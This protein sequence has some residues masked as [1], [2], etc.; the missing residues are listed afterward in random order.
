MSGDPLAII[1]LSSPK[2]QNVDNGHAFNLITA[3][4]LPAIRASGRRD[5]IRPAGLTDGIDA[6]PIVDLDLPR[7]DFRCATLEFLIGLLTVACPPRDDWSV[8]WTSPPSKA[9]LEAAF[10]PFVAAFTLDGEGAR[11][12]QDFEDLAIEPTPVEALLI[13][14]PGAAT[15]KR[16]AALLVKPGRVEVLSRSAAAIALLTL[17]TMA[18]AGGAGHRTSLR[19]GGPLTTLVVPTT[20]ATLWH[21]LWA[22]VPVGDAHPV[23]AELPRIFPWLAPTRLSNEDGRTTTP[24]DVDWRQA[25]FGVPRRIRLD[26]EPNVDRL[27]CDLT[28]EVDEVIVRTYRTRRH[29][30]NYDAWGGRHPLTPHYRTKASDP[31]LYPVHGQDTRISYREWVAVLYGSKD[32]LRLPAA[33]ISLFLVER[34]DALPP[35]GR[36][37]RLMAAGYAMDNMKALAFTEAET[38]DIVVP[39]GDSEAVAAK[40]RDFVAAANEVARAL[41]QVVTMALYGENADTRIQ[42]LNDTTPLRTARAR[43]WAQTN[44]SFFETL[45]SF[46]VLR[47]EEL[48]LAAAVPLGRAWRAAMERAVLTIF[49]DMAS[50][51]DALST[52]VKRVVEGRRFLVRTL[53]G[54]GARGVTLFKNLQL[55]VPETKIRKGKAA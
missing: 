51:R 2:E 24:E 10:A 36:S 29:G 44:D 1:R 22:N 5:R 30:T 8:R 52:D 9:K 31:V 34:K 33:C 4:W 45:N 38:P 23:P 3:A 21:R 54:Y 50:V 55:P 15:L 18:P 48:M 53:L 43:F 37:F 35:G 7:A 20:P 25:F 26:F 12:Y 6:D 27:P 13:E 28:G 42:H 47:S 19:G 40:A 39:E 16:N 14:A 46:S 17:Q 41:G 49:D 32:G 11:A